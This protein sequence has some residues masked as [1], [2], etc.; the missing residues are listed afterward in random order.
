MSLVSLYNHLKEFFFAPRSPLPLALYRIALAIIILQDLVIMLLPDFKLYYGDNAIVPIDQM[1]A[2]WWRLEPYF[3]MMVLLPPGE[4]WR[5]AFVIVMIILAIMMMFGLCFRFS[6]VA[7]WLCILS[8]D[9]HFQL[10]QNSGDN[11]IKFSTMI[12]CMSNAGD[13]LSIDN[14]IRAAR[15][16]WRQTGFAPRL[17]AP[18]AQR[19]LQLQLAFVY[20]HSFVC[21]I[22]GQ[23]WINGEACY[24]ASRYEDMVR[25]PMPFLFE[26]LWACK[27]LTWFTLVI[28]CFLFTLIW[29]KETCY[30]VLLGGLFLHGG[31]EYTT[32]LPMFEWLFMC[33]YVTF[34]EP[35]DLAKVMDLVRAKV[36]PLF[37][38]P[39][40]VSYDGHCILCTRTVGLIHRLD[41]FRCLNF[42]DFR[43]QENKA[44]LS[45]V[46]E[47]RLE[48]EMLL[49]SKDGFV[50]G[51]FAFRLISLLCPLLWPLVP[52]LY[53]PGVSLI[54]QK[55]YEWCAEHRYL[56]LGSNCEGEVCLRPKTQVAG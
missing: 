24:Y 48:K 27:I 37:G 45:A 15:E 51:F 12:I 26:N 19:M 54:G 17:S 36:Q 31:I 44:I 2:Y 4:Q 53:I 18:W 14:L 5:Y 32:N 25:F 9:N 47:S 46:E 34:V 16:D 21:K 30:W 39:Y 50:G 3:D 41:I 52:I 28:E 13:A 11:F 29:F 35:E 56:F 23:A 10:N 1:A 8:L 7:L 20:F 55:V 42:V 22:Q 6:S 33:V 43:E 40:L 49:K 38:A